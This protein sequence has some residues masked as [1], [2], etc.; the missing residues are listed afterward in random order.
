[1]KKKHLLSNQQ[2]IR[3]PS[4]TSVKGKKSNK[5]S[6]INSSNSRSTTK[7]YEDLIRDQTQRGESGKPGSVAGPQEWQA[8]WK[9]KQIQQHLKNPLREDHTDPS[10]LLMDKISSLP[11]ESAERRNA[12]VMKGILDNSTSNVG[13]GTDSLTRESYKDLKRLAKH[14]NML[15]SSIED[16]KPQSGQLVGLEQGT[17]VSNLQ[18]WRPSV[19][20]AVQPVSD[21]IGSHADTNSSI[22]KSALGP[23]QLL[24]QT[25]LANAKNVSSSM[26]SEVENPMKGVQKGVLVQTPSKESGSLRHLVTGGNPKTSMPFD[27]VSDTYNGLMSMINK[28]AKAIDMLMN[29]I[30]AF[31]ISALG[32][33]MDALFPPGMLAKLIQ[34]VQM[35][36]KL[37][38]DLFALLGGFRALSNISNQI[39]NDQPIGCT[40]NI[41]GLNRASSSS[42]SS[43][44]RA[45]SHGPC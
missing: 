42:S 33:L 27:L 34:L 41:F 21:A 9:Q 37:I 26:V 23:T 18:S 12:E 24:P 45:A 17:V 14:S 20:N 28:A 10:P 1:M 29:K 36:L 44:V 25:A 7:S 4:T 13:Y 6:I 8:A 22:T 31:A 35:I 19:A 3:V 5:I 16:P 39:L 2:P 43:S 40:G 32:G 15:Q 38:H 30:I 11:A